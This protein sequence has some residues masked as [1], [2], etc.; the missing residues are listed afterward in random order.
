[1]KGATMRTRILIAFLSAALLAQSGALAQSAQGSQESSDKFLDLMRTDLKKD[2]VAIIGSAMG[3]TGD[4]AA[5]FWPVYKDYEAELTPIGDQRVGLIKDYAASYK[6]MSNEKAGQLAV[7]AMDLRQKRLDL[8]KK[9]YQ[10]LAKEMS[11]IV[12]ARFLQVEDQLNLIL[13][14]KIAQE[15]PLIQKPGE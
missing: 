7:K 4:E 15:L 5:K 13:D 11:P 2:K 9:Y 8:M 12:A 14:L 3:F 1:M 10:R 6:T